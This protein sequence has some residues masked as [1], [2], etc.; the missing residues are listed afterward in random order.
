MSD[1]IFN[2][3]YGQPDSD[4]TVVYQPISFSGNCDVRVKVALHEDDLNIPT[5]IG[6]W[7]AANWHERECWDMFGIV[8]TGHP[9]LSRIYTP[10]TWV[11]H[12]LRKDHPA[13]ATEMEPYSHD[14]EIVDHEQ[15][16][17][18]FKPEEWGLKRKSDTS[19][20]M[21]MNFG[22]NH[23]AAHEVQ[24]RRVGAETLF[25]LPCNLMVS[26]SSMWF[27][28]SAITIAVLRRWANA[29]PGIPISPIPTGLITSVVS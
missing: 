11:G 17:M 2:E 21:F 12:P 23:P 3:L 10:P 25:A 26:M 22:P 19:E 28:M 24:A 16:A 14:D 18:K 29:R 15:E 4:F 27:L 8:F 6:L 9:N 7:P 5:A 20:F 1:K 13:R